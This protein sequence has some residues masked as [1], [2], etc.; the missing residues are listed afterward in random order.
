MA[1]TA[2]GDQP[3]GAAGAGSPKAGQGGPGEVGGGG[4]G[5]PGSPTPGVAGVAGVAGVVGVVVSGTASDRG[6]A[7][8][9]APAR[10]FASREA[11]LVARRQRPGA[12]AERY[13]PCFADSTT[14]F[15]TAAAG[16]LPK[17]DVVEGRRRRRRFF[18]TRARLLAEEQLDVD[19][20]GAEPRDGSSGG[21]APARRPRK[22]FVLGAVPKTRA[23]VA[24]DR[25]LR[26]AR[27][28]ERGVY[29]PSSWETMDCELDDDSSIRTLASRSALDARIRWEASRRIDGAHSREHSPPRVVDPLDASNKIRNALKIRRMRVYLD[30]LRARKAYIVDNHREEQGAVELVF[31]QKYGASFDD[32]IA[33]M[34]KSGEPVELP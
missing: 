11:E 3:S 28:E 9:G 24:L 8:G 30:R 16:V 18:T 32:V 27:E 12:D 20:E 17:Y 15:R 22:V 6:A 1:A 5:E 4:D 34:A 2:L 29:E 31:A 10:D 33:E 25:R 21:P 19:D 26:R 7:S 23:K 14:L 13:A